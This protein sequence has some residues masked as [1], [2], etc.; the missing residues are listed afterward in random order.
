MQNLVHVENSK[1]EDESQ[2]DVGEMS[3]SSTNVILIKSRICLEASSLGYGP[4]LAQPGAQ[5]K[6]LLFN[7]CNT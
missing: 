5:E 3:K 7:S 1:F 4:P 6:R 2:F